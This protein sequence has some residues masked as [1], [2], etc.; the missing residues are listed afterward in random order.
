MVFL[1]SGRP[2]WLCVAI[3]LLAGA[4]A[5]TSAQNAN[6]IS[7]KDLVPQS[8]GIAVPT[9]P[10][11]PATTLSV[12]SSMTAL[13]GLPVVDV[14]FRGIRVDPSVMQTLRQ[15]V[16][17]IESA[18]LDRQKVGK[19][20]RDLYATGRFSDL[21]VEAQKN[22][23]NE[24]SLVFV[25]TENLFIGEVTVE[26]APKRPTPSQLIDAS[27][28]ELGDLYAPEMVEQAVGRMKQA[29]ADNGFYQAT[30]TVNEQAS[31][32]IQK[33]SLMF[34]AVPGA[35]ARIGKITVEGD[36]GM[37]DA[38]VVKIAKLRP[39]MTV[40][41]QR[42]TSAL[43]RLRKRFTKRDHL[44]AQIAV[45][46]KD[47]RAETNEL[48]YTLSINRGPVIDVRVEGASVSK[49]KLQ[50]Y[51]PV[52]EEHA[53]DDDLLTEGRRNLRYFFQNKGYFDVNVDYARKA[54]PE[55]NRATIIY[56][57]DRGRKHDLEDVFIEGNKFFPA[58]T[59]KERMTVQKASWLVRHGR[60]S[61]EFLTRDIQNVKDLYLSNGFLQVKV[62][63]DFQDD[64]R[65]R[66]GRM[67]VFLHIEEG[68]QTLVAKVAIEGNKAIPD[69]Q[70]V[71]LLTM[72]EGQAYAEVNVLTDRDSVLNYYFNHGFPDATFSAKATPVEGEATKMAVEYTI[73]EGP[74]VFVD[75]VLLS[76]LEFTREGVVRRQFD[77]HDGD[78]LSQKA[79][80]DT[81][82]KLYDLGVF[83][84]VEMA[85][86]NPEGKSRYKDLFFQFEEA[87]RW[88]FNYSFGI[89]IQPGTGGPSTSPQGETSVSPRVGLDITRNNIGGRAHTLTF[90][91][92][93]GSLQQ[94]GLIAYDA[95]RFM[96][97]ENF[98]LTL[99][100][101][102]SNSLD[103]RTFTSQRLEGSIQVEQVVSRTQTHIPVTT[104]LYRFTYRRVRATDVVVSPSLIP[105]YSLPVRVGMPSLSFIR[106]RR[107]DPIETHR[108]SL[109]TFD[110]GVAAK[111]FGSEATFGR[112]SGQNTT[113]HGF[114]KRGDREWVIARNTRVG[115]AE[116]FGDTKQLP[117]PERFFAGGAGSHRGFAIN[118][119]GPRDLTTGQPLGGNAVFVNS[120]ELR[121]PPVV[122]P[123]VADNMSLA[124]FHD[125]GNV[126]TNVSDMFP[127]MVRFTQPHKESCTDAATASLC[128]FNYMSHAIGMGVRYKTPVGPV[129]LDFGYNLNPPVFPV[130]TTDPTTKITTFSSQTL[131]HFN[132]FFSIGQ[133]F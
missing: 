59:I 74:Q 127:S 132:F 131:R 77:I 44:E 104:L 67:A 124:I 66:A 81:Q 129:R 96:R 13:Q 108:G 47:Y 11:S 29:L 39:G 58:P 24:V 100:A 8:S 43:Q 79:M 41:M 57:V 14:E 80:L 128:E 113:Y 26:G 51:V 103:V 33:M 5:N 21:Q 55:E 53:V 64:Y 88:T 85:V 87:K 56:D 9:Q 37:S 7:P 32:N 119:A 99:S 16:A 22:Q 121:T 54:H 6:P 3:V 36:S 101:F 45:V 112:F 48:D 4:L 20:L 106:D 86:S 110:T 72:Q 123:F 73:D 117:L 107:D 76:G 70:L 65:G 83:N 68:P 69:E 23:K 75:R 18:P 125:M 118:Q 89:E 126:F 31:P 109:N 27:K 92:H 35:A 93:V 102:Y 46:K 84:A 78:P 82:R 38:E 15:I 1:Q 71:A 120:V 19:S 63:G 98:R 133:T 49:R 30:V 40:S 50:Q 28:V 94:L 12:G 10:P 62:W 114:H 25:A 42:L 91:S 95:P 60:F 130:F 97:N 115:V 122:M 111:A 90:K 116:P 105:L 52:Y 34:R 17:P 61:Q 2:G